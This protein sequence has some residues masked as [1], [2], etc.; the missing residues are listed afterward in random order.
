M[1]QAGQKVPDGNGNWKEIIG[2]ADSYDDNNRLITSINGPM[3]SNEIRINKTGFF[4]R[5]FLD[6]TIGAST[7]SKMSTMWYPRFRISEA[8]MIAC[9][10]AYEL[11][12]TGEDD[13]LNYINPVRTRA[14]ISELES[15]TFE[16][17]VREYRVEFALEDHRYW[18][19][20]RWRLAHEIWMVI[21]KIRMHSSTNYSLIRLMIRVAP[22]TRCGYSTKRKPTWFLTPAISR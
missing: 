20:K 14:G 13:P 17:I 4:F 2:K 9:E 1:L 12:K 22:M 7:N 11:N 16:D 15:I 3:E 21:R 18:D 5:K 8:Y 19:L 10:A 6:E